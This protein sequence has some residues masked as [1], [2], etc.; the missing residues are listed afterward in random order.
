MEKRTKGKM[1]RV[2]FVC[3]LVLCALLA[4]VWF[5]RSTATNFVRISAGENILSP[6]KPVLVCK[7]VNLSAKCVHYYPDFYVERWNEDTSTWETYDE[8]NWNIAVPLI[9]YDVRPFSGETRE[10]PLYVYGDSYAPGQ[11][12]VV[13]QVGVGDGIDQKVGEEVT[14]YCEF[15]VKES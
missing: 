8:S 2:W 4:A 12:R 11:Y 6:Q 1:L 7:V 15:T 14:L 9:V 5:S 3:G 10:Y 13:Q